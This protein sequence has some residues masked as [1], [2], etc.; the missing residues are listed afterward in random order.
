MVLGNG[1][2]N[3]DV[4]TR[5]PVTRLAEDSAARN[6]GF[7]WVVCSY[8]VASAALCHELKKAGINYG[9]EPPSGGVPD[10][11]VLGVQAVEDL[12]EA[13]GRVHEKGTGEASGASPI[14]VFAPQNDSKLAEAS[15][16]RGARGFVHAEMTP[17]QILRAL[18]AV[19]RGKIA[20][21]R[22]LLEILLAEERSNL[23][24]LDALS[25]RQR[26]TLE[27]VAEGLTNAQI[28]KRLY[29][30]ESTVKQHLVGAYKALGVRNR[31]QAVQVL[32]G[33]G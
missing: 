21:P 15:L 12:P 19:S 14:I 3:N 24:D 22:G 5:R 2:G 33:A 7:V 16:R 30:A 31:A 13:M 29:L 25:A 8:S 23:V 9:I 20:A 4:I 18:S 32:R 10:C 11:V 6:L 28:A 26:E 27:L 1:N 17:K